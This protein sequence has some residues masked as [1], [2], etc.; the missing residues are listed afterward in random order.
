MVDDFRVYKQM[1]DGTPF[2]YEVHVG[3]YKTRPNSVITRTGEMF[4]YASPEETPALMT[5]LVT[6]YNSEEEKGELHPIELASLLHYRYI[7]IHP[8]EDGNGRVARL[9]V[10]YVLARH[11]WP[12]LVVK[13][14][15]RD[16]YIYALD[17]CNGLTGEVPSDGAKATMEQIKPFCLYMQE[18]LKRA[19]EDAITFAHGGIVEEDEAIAKKMKQI[20]RV[21]GNE[22]AEP[23]LKLDRQQRCNVLDKVYFPLEASIV[24]ALQF[25]RNL[26]DTM[27]HQNLLSTDRDELINPASIDA[28]YKRADPSLMNTI[29]DNAKAI[30]FFCKLSNS[31]KHPKLANVEIEVVFKI[32]FETDFYTVSYLDD[33]QFSYGTYPSYDEIDKILS[34]C[35]NT[36]LQKLEKAV[37]R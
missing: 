27:E 1:P 36:V 16:N 2:Y 20:E 34:N 11:G 10:N 22:D 4:Y 7:R 35:K 28:D 8:F 32:I 3:V 17:Q 19:L 12:M 18:Q 15:D 37:Y 21:V 9:L 5:D 14:A 24:S 33:K 25:S 13:S 6:W 31:G 26:L 29:L 30:F 23:N